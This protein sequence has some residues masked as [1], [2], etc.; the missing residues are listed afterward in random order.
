MQEKENILQKG[1]SVANRFEIKFPI[2][3]NSFAQLNN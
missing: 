3:S 1:F 2:G